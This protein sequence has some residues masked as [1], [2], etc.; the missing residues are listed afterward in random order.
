MKVSVNGTIFEQKDA[1][2]SIADKA[3]WYDFGVY[4]NIK[5]LQGK[6]M[7]PEMHTYRLF[8]SAEI[9]GLHI[10]EEKERIL[11]WVRNYAEVQ[12]LKDHIIK[13]CVYGDADKNAR[14]TVY[15]FAIGLTFYPDQFYAQGVKAITYQGER[16]FPT[17]KSMDTLVNFIAF[18]TAKE[19]GAFE[20]ILIDR[21]GNAREG[22]RSNLY[23]V[24][25]ETIITPPLEDVLEGVTRVLVL[26]LLEEN[27]IP[28][29]EERISKDRLMAADEIF[30]TATSS[31]VMSVTEIDQQKIGAGAPGEATKQII[32]LYRTMQK[33]YLGR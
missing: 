3:V 5:V 32:Q 31:N 1:L 16:N 6:I 18:R 7:W 13:I 33:E 28:F 30:I 27:E 11:Q 4:E 24:E 2:V 26:K 12:K 23:I 17:A 22:S 14:A 15:M 19:R 8:K 25:K 20:A 21:E 10:G 9:I 29:K